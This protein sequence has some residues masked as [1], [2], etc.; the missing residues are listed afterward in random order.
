MSFITKDD[1]A[2][3]IRDNVL[4]DIT[5]VDDDKIEQQQDRAVQFMIGYL[6]NRY[7]TINIFNKVGTARDVVIVAYAVDITIYY[8]HR[9][10]N[11]RKVPGDRAKAYT[12]AKEWLE[13]VSACKI[14]PP[15][16]PLLTTGEKDYVLWGSNIKR[17]NHI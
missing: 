15:N 4:D 6:N 7:D 17:E 11:Y 14:N 8:L 5:E 9:L 13:N 1:Y 3:H 16:L 10:M 12:E 2:G